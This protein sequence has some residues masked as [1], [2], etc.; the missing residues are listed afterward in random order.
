MENKIRMKNNFF[1]KIII[2]FAVL[3]Y[4]IVVPYLE[5]NDTHVF[6]PDWT[7][8]MRIHEVWQLLTNSSLGF[9]CLY[10][11]WYKND[12][13]LGGILS[14]LIMGGFLISFAIKESYGGSMKYLDG[15]ENTILGVNMGVLGFGTAFGLILLS[16][17]IEKLGTNK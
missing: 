10:L 14:L 6:N 11:L 3:L 8:H 13:K 7:P 16:F 12:S 5:I 17:A 4:A 2:T 15:S 1:Q 9:L